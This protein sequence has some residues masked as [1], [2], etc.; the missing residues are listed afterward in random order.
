MKFNGIYRL[1]ESFSLLGSWATVYDVTKYSYGV[2]LSLTGFQLQY[3]R[4]QSMLNSF[5]FSEN[6]LERTKSNS[7]IIYKK[8][9]AGHFDILSAFSLLFSLNKLKEIDLKFLIQENKKRI[10]YLKEK[11]ID[12]ELN[13]FLNKKGLDSSILS[14]PNDKKI[15]E[16]LM[17]N[18][19]YFSLRGEFIRFSIH[20]YNNQNDLE[21]L[22]SILKEKK[23]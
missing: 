3:K 12:L 7:E 4:V 10:L 15:Y 9:Y 18:K 6:F 16:L 8:V 19:V 11:L 1:S 21:N 23:A 13:P 20:F 17:K 2:E 14:I 22:V 5:D